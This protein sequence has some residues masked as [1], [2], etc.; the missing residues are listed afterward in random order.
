MSTLEA[1]AEPVF[2]TEPLVV[3]RSWRL[4]LQREAPRICPI[5]DHGHPWSPFAPLK[6]ACARRRFHPAPAPG[7]ACGI[8]GLKDVMVL[9]STRSPAVIGTVALWG[10]VIEHQLGFRGEF[11]YPQRLR[12]VC[13]EC[14]WRRGPF[15][16]DPTFVALFRRGTALP[17]CPAHLAVARE[18]DL[19]IRSVRSASE[20]EESLLSAYAV[21]LLP[22]ESSQKRQGEIETVSTDL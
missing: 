14:F 20:M 8:Y 15:A 18:C 22:A 2:S 13:V 12:L 16:S 1:L 9:G 6:A 21:D 7:C 19:H 10:R 4:C 3:W 11:A 5:G 17:L